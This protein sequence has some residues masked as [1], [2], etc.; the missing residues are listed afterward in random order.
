MRQNLLL[1][2]F[3][4]FLSFLLVSAI[5]LVPLAFS[6]SMPHLFSFLSSFLSCAG[7]LLALRAALSYFL[8]DK[9]N[10]SLLDAR[11]HKHYRARFF[12]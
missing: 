7:S 12:D 4:F 2:S 5:C 10:P 6:V 1:L 8:L 9:I 11:P 3:Q